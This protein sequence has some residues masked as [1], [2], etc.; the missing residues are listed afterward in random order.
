MKKVLNKWQIHFRFG[1]DYRTL[2]RGWK[3]ITFGILKIHTLS[4]EGEMLNKR[5]YAGFL[6]KFLV[7]FPIDY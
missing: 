3:E 5:N 7:W 2:E 1:R 6:L 4:D